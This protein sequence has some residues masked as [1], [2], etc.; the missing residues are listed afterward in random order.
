MLRAGVGVSSQAQ[1]H[2]AADE[3]ARSALAGLEGVDA[4]LLFATPGY[5]A[6]LPALV[7]AV[8]AALGTEQVIGATAHGVLGAGVEHEG[9]RSLGVLALAGLEA[10]A[11]LIPH[12]ADE[13]EHV[14]SEIASRIGRPRPEDLVV[15]LP[16]PRALRAD[17]LLGGLRES[18]GEA[19]VVG[20]GA[21]DALSDDPRQW[22]GVELASGALAG[23]VLRSKRAPRVGVT[24]A[25]RPIT[26]LLQVTRSEG[27]WVLEL[28]GRPALEV[29]REAARGPLA[30]D[31]RRAAAFV[32]AALPRDV[33]A[34]LEPGG[35]LVRNVVGFAP[36]RGAFALPE[37]V[38]Q[39]S[40]L[41]L[42]AREPEAAR[43][44]LK[45]MLERMGSEPPG[46]GLYF[47]CM[48]RGAGLFGVPGLEAAYLERAFGAAPLLGMFGSCEIGPIA[49]RT[50]LLTYTGVIAL[51]EA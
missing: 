48:A 11:F 29:Y 3:A 24:Q 44:D 19:C 27:H 14:G 38:V 16:D 6:D 28:E 4:A 37:P 21:V 32:L 5:G 15:L 7:A 10:H 12:L 9:G 22:C 13:C 47:D 20:A 43:A 17:A 23:L 46:V 45:R 50:E 34:P 2:A 26:A 1:A 33:R 41:A 25:C 18:L 31:L 30:A 49:G 36:E 39:G 42:V 40:Q 35:Y 8:A 51:I